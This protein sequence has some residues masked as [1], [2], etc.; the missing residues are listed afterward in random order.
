MDIRRNRPVTALERFFVSFC[1]IFVV[2]F[3][4]VVQSLADES[5]PL[6]TESTTKIL[7][8]LTPVQEKMFG[9]VPTDDS[10]LRDIIPLVG[11]YIDAAITYSRSTS[12]AAAFVRGVGEEANQFDYKETVLTCIENLAAN[13]NWQII[14]MSIYKFSGS[15]KR[16]SDRAFKNYEADVLLLMHFVYFI[17]P[18]LD[19]IRAQVSVDALYKPSQTGESEYLF[20]RKY[21]YLSASQ[22]DLFRPFHAGE[23]EAMIEAIENDYQRKV[24]E[25]PNNRR[26]YRKDRNRALAA[27]KDR[28][29]ILPVMALSEG[30]QGDSFFAGLRLATDRIREMLEMDWLTTAADLP[31]DPENVTF[32][33][34]DQ[35]GKPEVFE[36]YVVG[37]HGTNTIYR[38]DKGNMYSVP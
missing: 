17:T 5:V 1:F 38:D 30:W 24:Q 28:E 12:D 35:K 21:E 2:L 3:V 13:V 6:R 18:G 37:S 4:L 16:L 34:F 7:I 22:G 29:D 26:A 36:G 15:K 27:L 20:S 8:V 33:G 25:F 23:K 10:T 11:D 14:D 9:T 32:E 31:E 19:Q